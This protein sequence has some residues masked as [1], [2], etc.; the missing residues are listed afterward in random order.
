MNKSAVFA[1]IIVLLIG[2]NLYT[3]SRLLTV[4]REL[5]ATTQIAEERT[6]NDKVLSFTKLFIEKVLKAKG[7]VSF[8]DRLQL[9]NMVRDLKDNE[10]LTAWNTFVD[11]KTEHDA[12]EGVKSLL[13]ILVNKIKI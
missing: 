9:E 4:Q 11:S 12:Q 3:I 7:E 1:V 5:T 2:A 10:I 6:V 8:E 13:T